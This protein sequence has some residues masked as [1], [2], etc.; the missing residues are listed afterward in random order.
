MQNIK[1]RLY[2]IYRTINTLPNLANTK[3]IISQYIYNFHKLIYITK[4]E[5]RTLFEKKC[6]NI[7][8]AFVNLT[9]TTIYISQ[10]DWKI[11]PF[12]QEL[13]CLIGKYL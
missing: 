10:G 13:T 5:I 1:L 8:G 12:E 9:E 11:A 4:N 7:H 6:I 3:Y 2:I